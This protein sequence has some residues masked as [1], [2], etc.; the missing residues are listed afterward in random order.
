MNGGAV[1]LYLHVPKTAGTSLI[2]VIYRQHND[3]TGSREEGGWF[4][5]G[6]YYYPGEPDFIRPCK[7]HHPY[8]IVQPSSI[9]KALSRDDLRVVA[10][11]F[12]FGLHTIVDRPTTYA[13]M[14]RHPVDRITSL[15]YH[16]KRWP[17]HEEHEPWLE[18]VG[19]RPVG[20]EISLEQFIRDYPL[21]ELDNDQTRRLAGQ[22]PE[23]GKC[24]R[25]L[26]DLAKSN[27][28]NHFSF[29]GITERFEESL[30]VAGDEFDWCTQ[31]QS[32]K[33]LVNECRVPTSLIPSSAREAILERNT[34][35]LEL[36]SFANE[37]LND[38]FRAVRP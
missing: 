28:E 11:H 15:Y 1:L 27:I 6:V 10:G 20:A 7:P 21:R 18:R 12:S 35:D 30:L 8:R 3:S 23:F 2:D 36:Y 32:C 37:R 29:V 9:L 19:L 31:G 13:T 17:R 26:L 34:L 4:C 16:L 33:E 14:L 25:S 5:N 22:D 24:N 38:R